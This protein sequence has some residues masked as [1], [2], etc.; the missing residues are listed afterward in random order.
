MNRQEFSDSFTTILN[1]YRTIAPYG[2]EANPADIVLDEFEKSVYLTQAQTQLVV[3][4]YNGKNPYGDSF[5]STEEMR[6]YLD[7]L[8]K[9]GV[10]TSIEDTES[11]VGGENSHVYT[12]PEDVLFITMEQ[13][14]YGDE[15]EC[16]SIKTA[17]VYPIT[18]DSFGMV[19]NNPFRGPT[20][21]KAIRL[22]IGKD[23]TGKSKVE[24]ISKFPISEYKL[25]Y[26]KKPNPIILVDL[27]EPLNISGV[28][29][30]TE[31]ELPEVLHERI[32]EQAVR[33]ALSTRVSNQSK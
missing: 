33:L 17:N 13:V 22:D 11:I 1:S 8:V 9:T 20:R 30:A 3:S 32:L 19:R 18:Q 4:L 6:R 23:I 27:D 7:S 12:I 26:I 29:T 24:I 2:T 28:S 21:Y 5:E 31:C 15:V 16:G 25:R 14:T 10:G